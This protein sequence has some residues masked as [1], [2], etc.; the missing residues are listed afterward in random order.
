[1]RDSNEVPRDRTR[2]L[3][4]GNHWLRVATRWLQSCHRWLRGG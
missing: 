4:G 3:G 2:S 1:V